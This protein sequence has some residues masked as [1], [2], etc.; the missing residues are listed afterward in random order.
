MAFKSKAVKTDS[1]CAD[2]KRHNPWQFE[3]PSYD[4]RNCIHAGD[5]FGIGSRQPIGHEGEAK[6]H[7]DAL[8]QECSC[9]PLERKC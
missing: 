9:H 1:E 6:Q 7:V 2:T 5:E 3:A 4:N 8:P